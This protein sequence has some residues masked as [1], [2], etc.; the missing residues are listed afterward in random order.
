MAS[1][2]S[3]LGDLEEIAL[4]VVIALGDAAYGVA[5]QQRIEADARRRIALGS[6]YAALDR[7]ERRGYLRSAFGEATAERGGRRKRIFEATPAAVRAL[8]DLKR[9]RDRLWRA[10]EA[11][12]GRG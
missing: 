9:T 1:T 6:V 3:T 5:V 12:E 8:T 10:A 11:A 7:L 4:L 2:S